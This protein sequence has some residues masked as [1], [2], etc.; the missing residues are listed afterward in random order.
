MKNYYIT[1]KVT[2]TGFIAELY[3]NSEQA[4]KRMYQMLDEIDTMGVGRCDGT[5]ANMLEGLP[6]VSWKIVE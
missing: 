5:I 3:T 6:N 2:L 4:E 1:Y